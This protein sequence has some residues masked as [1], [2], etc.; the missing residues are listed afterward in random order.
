MGGKSWF[1]KLFGFLESDDYD[2]NRSKFILNDE[3]NELR[4]LVNGESFYIGKF[5]CLS[6]F[7]L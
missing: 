5:E 4:S 7:E 3:Q 1:S 6:L 2:F